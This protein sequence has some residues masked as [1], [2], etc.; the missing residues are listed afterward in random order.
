V[1]CEF[2]RRGHT[3]DMILQKTDE[4]LQYKD[5]PYR[6]IQ[7]PGETYSVPGQIRF[8]TASYSPLKRGSYQIIHARNPFSSILSAAIL[9]K[10]GAITSKI[11]Y[12]MRGLWINFGVLSGKISPHLSSMLEKTENHLL[13]KC[14]HIIAISPVLK[15]VLCA[16]GLDEDK[17]SVIF[18]GGANIE[19]IESVPPAKKDSSKVIGYV[20]TISTSRQSHKIIEA[21]KKIERKD[22]RLVMIGPVGEPHIFRELT[23]SCENIVLTGYLPQEKAFHYLKSFDV[24]LS[25]HDVD[26]PAYNV[27]VP[28]KVFEYMASGVPIVT[29][30]HQMYRNVLEDGRTA[31]LTQQNPEDFARGIVHLLENPR[32]AEEISKK[33]RSEVEKY[34][35]KNIA[36]QME[37]VYLTLLE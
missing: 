36:D 8:V 37:S 19:K 34:S 27:A 20:G 32:I 24:A 4:D 7:I 6:L 12:D 22:I 30:D 29:T 15:D 25:Y 5:R 10:T 35:V 9:K 26:H 14:D 33:A 11:V 1:A 13:K 2:E 28:V 17:I 23:S 31:V 21:F 3:I 16:R 18:G